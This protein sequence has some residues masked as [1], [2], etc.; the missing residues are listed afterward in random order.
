MVRL[1]TRGVYGV[2]LLL[3]A[4]VSL[5]LIQSVSAQSL[6]PQTVDSA[7]K[8]P[9]KSTK[10][11]L[12]PFFDQAD[13][14]VTVRFPRNQK[15]DITPVPPSLNAF[16]QKVLNTCGTFGSKV[17][18]ISIRRLLSESPQVVQQ[19]KQ[20][21]GGELFSG[22]RSDNQFRD[23]LVTIWSDRRAFEH[24]FC[25]QMRGATQIGGLHFVGRYL[26]LQNQGIAGRLPNNSKAEE[27]IAGEV[28]TLGVEIRQGDRVITRD[29]KKGYSY[30]SN[31]QE[32]LVD[33]T[34]AFKAFRTTASANQ[35]CLY[36]VRDASSAPPFQAVFVKTNRA[37]VTFYPD[38]TPKPNEASCGQ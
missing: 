10:S 29:S 1:V 21:V 11:G 34:R 17:S 20:T 6:Q 18:T 13:N 2:A 38:A 32:I 5:P 16:D 3:I 4:G 28:Y 15:V 33:A 30:V 14:L 7:K 36:T 9:A 24:I 25:G 37:I 35:A 27:V 26:Q 8:R 23:D 19:I 22:R 12:L 31:A